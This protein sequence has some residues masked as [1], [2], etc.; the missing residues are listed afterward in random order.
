MPDNTNNGGAGTPNANQEG[1]AQNANN[2]PTGAAPKQPDAGSMQ[3][4]DPLKLSDEDFG[5]F[6]NDPRAF[7]HSRFKDLNEKA[8]KATEYETEKKAE[9]EAKLL[10]EKKYQ[11]LIETRTKEVADWKGKYDTERINNQIIVEAQKLG[12]V[13]MDA[14]TKLIDRSSLKVTDAGIEGVKE[15][16]EA[17]KGSKAYLFGQAGS[18]NGFGNGSNPANVNTGIRFKLSQLQDAK[19]YQEHEKEIQEAYKNGMIENDLPGTS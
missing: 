4:F 8:K 16:L 2:N 3:S 11:E 6:F 12:G 10:E 15:A 19:F 17:L 7:T 13:D 18:Q 1:S 14:I 5:K 9:K